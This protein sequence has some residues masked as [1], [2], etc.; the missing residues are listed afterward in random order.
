MKRAH[1]SGMATAVIIVMATVGALAI[2]PL[3]PSSSMQ[4][5]TPPTS[6]SSTAT[7][8]HADPKPA[9]IEYASD[10]EVGNAADSARTPGLPASLQGTLPDGEVTLD[11]HGRILPTPGLRRLFD[12]FLSSI[13]ELDVAAIR[14]LLLAHV[15]GQHG[16]T[17]ARD[18]GEAFDRY[19]DYQRALSDAEPGL[20]SDLDARL[21]FAK[22][23]RRKFFDAVSADA[24]FGEEEAYA[25]YTLQRMR[26]AGDA[27]L[28]DAERA[29]R[30]QALEHT[31]SAEQRAGQ[32]QASTAVIA[33]EQSRQFDAIN[34]SPGERHAERSALFGEEAAH[35]LAELD[36]Q[37]SAW[38]QRTAA[39]QQARNA[40][41]LDSRYSAIQRE[42]MIGELRARSFDGNEARRVSALE[43]IGKL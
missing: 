29:S 37:R 26:I 18:V 9:A 42:R 3:W 24:Y 36:R 39:Y 1:R 25:E 27:S 20:G 16:D 19:V 8:A 15:R 4:L 41:Q 11:A 30:L 22:R 21:A 35:R 43:S 7:E 34:A 12:Y 10:P 40:I 6:A 31:L 28:D 17:I 38:D 14:A 23:L 32:Q 5:S 13:G 33:E 2:L